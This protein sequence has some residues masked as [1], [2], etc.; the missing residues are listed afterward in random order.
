MENSNQAIT[1]FCASRGKKNEE[2]SSPNNSENNDD[3]F[4]SIVI[5]GKALWRGKLQPLWLINKILLSQQKTNQNNALNMQQ[6]I[7]PNYL[8]KMIRLLSFFMFQMQQ[9]WQHS[10]SACLLCLFFLVRCVVMNIGSEWDIK[11]ELS[12]NS[13]LVSYFHLCTN[14]LQKDTNPALLPPA[15]G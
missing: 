2:D 12:S 15:M 6:I 5:L 14:T 10:I 9:K 11:A 1:K 8:P 13:S 4:L 7:G 3:T